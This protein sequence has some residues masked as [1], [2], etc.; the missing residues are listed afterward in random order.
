MGKLEKL[1]A[2]IMRGNSDK[3]ISFSDLCYVLSVF[4][5][6]ERIKGDHHIFSRED[7]EEILNIQPLGKMAKSYQVK[8][9]RDIVIK[10]HL[11]A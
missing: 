5:F 7:I 10:Y 11:G 9:V 6:R 2:K 8:Q 4:N 3:N 1:L